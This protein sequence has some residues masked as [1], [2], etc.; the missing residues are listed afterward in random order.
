METITFECETITPMF[1][2][3]ADGITP[4]LRAPS[5]KGA[6]RFW[7][8]AM[9][10]HLPLQELW[11]RE[12]K[13]FGSTKYGRSKVLI[14]VEEDLEWDGRSDASPTPHTHKP[15]FSKNAFRAGQNFSITL[16]LFY[17]VD[18]GYK[19]KF[20][21]ED[22]SNLFL[23]MATLGGI[24]GRVRRGFGAFNII[25]IKGGSEAK[26]QPKTVQEIIDLL[27]AEYFKLVDKK[28][29]SLKQR[30]NQY[31]Y[32]KEIEIGSPNADVLKKIGFTTHDVKGIN[33]YNYETALG[34][35]SRGRLASPIY[36]SVIKTAMGL[37]PIIVTLNTAPENDKR[38][39]YTLQTIFKNK[40]L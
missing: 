13:I 21:F 30:N 14:K 12:G 6:L 19:E 2:S 34:H 23:L 17:A 26:K 25:K 7:W 39:D 24:G 10:G 35:A 31:P 16:S 40:I 20:T 22:L 4:E 3:G 27:S 11:I 28:I 32:I 37:R 36:V 38:V 8:R 29:V 1:L 9:N 18:L 15:R 5:I 33:S